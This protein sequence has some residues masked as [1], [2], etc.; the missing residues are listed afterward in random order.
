MECSATGVDDRTRVTMKATV[1]HPGELGPDE[2]SR[3]QELLREAPALCHPFLSPEFAAAVGAVGKKARVAVVHDGP[4]DVGF[5]AYEAGPLRVARPLAGRLAYRQGFVHG[6]AVPWSWRGLL[7]AAGVDAVEFTDLVGEQT[8]ADAKGRLEVEDSP[9]IDTSDGWDA[10]L[11]RSK[12]RRVKNTRYLD[13]KLEREVGPVKFTWGEVDRHEFD[14]LVAWKSEQ[15]RR[16]G[17]P[18]P[19]AQRWVRELFEILIEERTGELQPIFTSLRAG[20][21]LLAVDLSLLFHDVYA[22]WFSAYNHEFSAYSPGAVRML[23][24]IEV[25]AGEGVRYLDLARGDERY[26]RSFKNDYLRVGAGM[27]HDGSPRAVA[28]RAARAPARAAR[29]Y[30]LERPR[31]RAFVR[32]SLRKVGA[33]RTTV[34]SRR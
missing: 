30:V 31:V 28:Y 32:S 13:R 16:S 19:F 21:H 24:T 22:G 20:D 10:Y 12:G 2:R 17:W 4:R 14:Q 1:C 29:S 3:W 8:N 18:D 11:A 7:D 5:F 27:L 33:V 23:R 15:Y 26:K 34:F 9:I 25:A 6:R